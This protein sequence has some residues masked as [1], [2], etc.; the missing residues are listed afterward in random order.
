MVEN[1]PQKS[2]SIKDRKMNDVTETQTLGHVG[3]MV[4]R[5]FADNWGGSHPTSEAADA[6]NKKAGEELFE[7]LSLIEKWLKTG[8][9]KF[10]G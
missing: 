8:K 10:V 1:G 9:R 7:P 6:A 3:Q 4:K 2:K 5:E